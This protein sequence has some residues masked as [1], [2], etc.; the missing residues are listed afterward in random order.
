VPGKRRSGFRPPAENRRV[1]P[2]LVCSPSLL[3]NL[4]TSRASNFLPFSGNLFFR[5]GILHLQMGELLQAYESLRS[6]HNLTGKKFLHP[7]IP[8]WFGVCCLVYKEDRDVRALGRKRRGWL[9][10][11]QKRK[12][13]RKQRGAKCTY[14]FF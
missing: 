12:E 7:R 1:C 13:E 2:F 4:H 6:A 3:K 10:A 9:S 11:G 5:Q 8:L 14:F